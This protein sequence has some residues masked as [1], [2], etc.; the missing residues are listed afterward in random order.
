MSIASE[1]SRL[2]AAKASLR[3]AIQAKGVTVPELAKLD[4]FPTYIGNIQTQPN[5]QNK[6]VNA[7]G[8]V[9][10][11]NGYDGLGTVTVN[12][13]SGVNN[14]NKSV[15]PSGSQQVVQPD[16]GYSGLGQVTVAAAQL[17]NKSVNA[18]GTVSPD[19][20]YYGLGAVVVNVPTVNNQNK[21][22]SPSGSQQT[23]QPDSGYSG[24]G[25]VTLNAAPLQS[26]SVTP[27]ASQQ[28]IQPDSGY[29][30]LS[31]VVV[32]AAQSGAT[33]V[34]TAGDIPVLLGLNDIG[35]SWTNTSWRQTPV[36]ITIPVS[37]T[38]RFNWVVSTNSSS[39]QGSTVLYRKRGNTTEQIGTNYS[40]IGTYRYSADIEC[41]ANDQ[42]IVG[43]TLLEGQSGYIQAQLMLACVAQNPWSNVSY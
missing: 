22:V 38:Y 15:S 33:L 18:N 5:L 20:G 14:Q 24:L 37:G 26:K 13:P 41:Q 32:D 43:V 2:Q 7:N 40:C 28:T 6:T 30:G 19:S 27:S 31:S 12:V 21:T 1:I 36:K 17:Q 8:Q 23:V 16:S 42:I 25:Q 29:Y 35:E 4:A 39:T 3:Q 10:A 9:T 11:D 34:P